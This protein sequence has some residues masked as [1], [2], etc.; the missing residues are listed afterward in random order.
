MQNYDT[1]YSSRINFFEP[2]PI[3]TIMSKISDLSRK[4]EVI[5]FAAGEPDPSVLPR[6]IFGELMKE[7]FEKV[8]L[9]GNYTPADGAFELREEIAKFMK[10]Y[11][12]VKTDPNKIVVT[13][14]GSQALDLLGRIFL[15]AGDIAISESPSYVN[16]LID[17]KQYGARIVGVPVDDS[18]MITDELEKTVKKLKGERKRV[19]L[20]YTIPTGQNPSGVT[21]IE[22]RRKH[23]LEIASQYDLILV[24][25]AAY[26]HLLYEG[27][28]PK[29]L[30]SMDKEG[31][32]I[33]SGTFSKILGTGLRI[34]WLEGPS[35]VMDLIKMVKG[36]TDMCAS[37]P[38][39][40]L[41][42]ESLR[43]G[44]FE[45]AKKKALENYKMKRDI[46]IKSIE[47]K[48]KGLKFTK[49]IAGMFILVWLKKGMDGYAFAEELLEKK[50]VAVVPAAAFY[51]DDSGKEVIRLNFSMV[52]PE[53]IEKG[54]SSI[55]ELL[56]F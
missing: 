56:G 3:R 14:G 25:D 51:T 45:D 55:A 10:K 48:L 37:T 41:V 2:S 18:G 31:R 30:R 22:E 13:I 32:V 17:W 49:P 42:I 39:Q 6:K 34:G 1:K 43:R 52:P 36:P 47:E 35:E 24:E 12:D 21:M 4:R 50:G 40:Y 27:Q 23:L 8:E 19:K 16:T 38:M 20:V 9:V 7:V 54:I 46:M 53:K 29:T 28:P 26:N 44:I 5:S 11:D 15:D 33:Y